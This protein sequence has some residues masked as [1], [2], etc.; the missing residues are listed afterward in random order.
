MLFGQ[1]G[2]VKAAERTA[3]QRQAIGAKLLLVVTDFGSFWNDPHA[4]VTLARSGG[5]T[6]QTDQPFKNW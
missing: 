3:D 1:P 5:A 6:N 2:S 4:L